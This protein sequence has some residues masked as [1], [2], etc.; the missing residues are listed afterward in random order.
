L[1]PIDLLIN[2]FIKKIFELINIV[3][4]LFNTNQEQNRRGEII[5][6]TKGRVC[7]IIGRNPEEG[8]KTG[9]LKGDLTLGG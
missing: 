2:C 6:L 5:C 8:Y 3:R 7:L 9:K 4:P 1:P